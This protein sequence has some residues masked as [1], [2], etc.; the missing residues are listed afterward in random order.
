MEVP[1]NHKIFGEKS[2]HSLSHRHTWSRRKQWAQEWQKVWFRKR[3]KCLETSGN[4]GYRFIWASVENWQNSV[5]LKKQKSLILCDFLNL[6]ESGIASQYWT[7]RPR[8]NFAQYRHKWEIYRRV[9]ARGVS[10][11]K[12]ETMDETD[13][14]TA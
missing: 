10:A 4:K 6:E 12:I 3:R 9:S 2:D 5:F 14:G 7:Y 11:V 1:E 8:P 13:A